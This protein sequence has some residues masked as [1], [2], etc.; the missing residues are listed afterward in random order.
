MA[1]GSARSARLRCIDTI[2]AAI[3]SGINA[4][5]VA[6]LYDFGE[7]ERVVGMALR[8]IRDRVQVFSKVGL[9]WDDADRYGEV[10][11]IAEDEHGREIAVRKNSRFESIRLEVE[12]SLRRFGLDSLD[13]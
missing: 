6:P 9:R 8:G 5:D 7:C 11:F 4:I 3:D 10:M 12:R 2:R 13:A 1:I